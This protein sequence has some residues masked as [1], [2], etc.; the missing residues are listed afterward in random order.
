ML[1]MQ[2]GT[3]CTTSEKT[4]DPNF[5]HCI[6]YIIVSGGLKTLCSNFQKPYEESDLW[7][8]A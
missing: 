2:Q 1:Q 3:K 7:K 5:F 8:D 4:D 6:W